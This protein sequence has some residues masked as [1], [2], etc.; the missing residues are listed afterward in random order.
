[1]E[2]I[3]IKKKDLNYRAD[4]RAEWVCSHGVGHTIV[5]PKEYVTQEAWWSH[6]CDGCCKEVMEGLD[7]DVL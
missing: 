1:M 3:K 6:T 4:G 7:G 2:K 5:V